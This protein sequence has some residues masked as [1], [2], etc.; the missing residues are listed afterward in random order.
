MKVSLEMIW[1]KVYHYLKKSIKLIFSCKKWCS[2]EWFCRGEKSSK[3]SKKTFLWKNSFQLICADEVFN[4]WWFYGS[5]KLFFITKLLITRERQKIIKLPHF[6]KL[7]KLVANYLA[8]LLQNRTKPQKVGAP[9]ISTGYKFF[10]KKFAREG[11]ITCF[12]GT[13]MQIRKSSKIFILIWK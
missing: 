13:L 6:R 2:N 7:A 9:R 5:E 4:F 3:L 1:K 8:K 11:C 10:Y 12:K